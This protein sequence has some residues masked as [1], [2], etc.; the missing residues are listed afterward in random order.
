LEAR[1]GW[2][3]CTPQVPALLLPNKWTIINKNIITYSCKSFYVHIKT[4]RALNN[5]ILH[6]TIESPYLFQRHPEMFCINQ[7]SRHGR[8]QVHV[9][10]STCT[11]WILEIS[12]NNLYFILFAHPHFVVAPS[13]D[14]KKDLLICVATDVA[15][16][17]FLFYIFI[18]NL[19]FSHIV[20]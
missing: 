1:F 5:K 10:L 8:S 6:E 12:T 2:A 7:I 13:L 14:P 17:L 11:P 18:L 9:R 15:L 4:M 20:K 3:P 19:L 16:E